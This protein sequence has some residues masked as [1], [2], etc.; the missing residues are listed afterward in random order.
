MGESGIEG[1][2]GEMSSVIQ[3]S[4]L[5]VIGVFGQASLASLVPVIWHFQGFLETL[6]ESFS[7]F[8]VEITDY[9]F[10]SLYGLFAKIYKLSR[11]KKV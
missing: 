5:P 1:I 3:V 4:F 8:V 2:I 6:C 9:A 11:L 7:I 10:A